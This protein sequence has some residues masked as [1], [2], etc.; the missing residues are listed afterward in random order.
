[1][2]FKA[3]AKNNKPMCISCGVFNT[4]LQNKKNFLILCMFAEIIGCN[5]IRFELSKKSTRHG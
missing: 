1:M 2:N 3:L 5:C 4:G